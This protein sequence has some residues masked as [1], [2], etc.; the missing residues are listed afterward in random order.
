MGSGQRGQDAAW[1]SR[2]GRG[3]VERFLEGLTLGLSWARLPGAHSPLAA[4][5]ASGP[6]VAGAVFG[7]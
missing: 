7:A 5:G 1:D 4:A 6:E 2:G 3:A